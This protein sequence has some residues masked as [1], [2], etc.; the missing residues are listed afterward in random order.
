M[1]VENFKWKEVPGFQVQQNLA[2]AWGWGASMSFFLLQV[3]TGVRT[4][5]PWLF[6]VGPLKQEMGKLQDD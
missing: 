1:L 3:P 5:T 4:E 6:G 2:Q